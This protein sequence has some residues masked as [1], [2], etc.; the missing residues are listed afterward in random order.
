MWG[1]DVTE[2]EVYQK[3]H[4]LQI[5]NALRNIFSPHIENKQVSNIQGPDTRHLVF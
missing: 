5:H 4:N 2:I 3:I 1:T